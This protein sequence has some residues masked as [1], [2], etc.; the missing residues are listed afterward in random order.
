MGN[1]GQLLVWVI[2]MV[3]VELISSAHQERTLQDLALGE[4]LRRAQAPIAG[5][6]QSC[7]VLAAP[8]DLSLEKFATCLYVHDWA[9]QH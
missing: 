3:V 9:W 6:L 5:S 2:Q 8:A 1:F 7:P 4:H